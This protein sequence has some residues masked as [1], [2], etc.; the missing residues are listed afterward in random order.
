MFRTSH[1]VKTLAT[2]D[3][4]WALVRDF[5]KWKRWL[6][7]VEHLQI[8]GPCVAG[9]PGLMH[10]SDGKVHTLQVHKFELGRIEIFVDLRFGVKLRLLV[11]VSSVPPGS[12]VTLEGELLGHMAILHFLGW[13]KNLK[14]GL[15]PTT[16]LLG[17]LGQE[18]RR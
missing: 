18:R 14:T 11:D 15:V 13:A 6:L 12:Q 16:R 4:A 7:G 1:T 9:V 17:L 5:S 10:L 3:E 8:N 2:P